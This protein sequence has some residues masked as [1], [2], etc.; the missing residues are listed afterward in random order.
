MARRRAA[1]RTYV[2]PDVVSIID[3]SGGLLDPRSLV[4]S[5]V[6]ALLK[7]LELYEVTFDN[8]FDR[9]CILASLAGFEVKAMEPAREGR[10]KHDAVIV[11][12]SG[13]SKRGVIFYNSNRPMSRIVF[14][15]A[16]EISHS[17]FPTSHTGARFRALSA[18]GSKDNLEL[19]TLCHFGASELTMPQDP[20][21]QVVDR[22]G[23]AISHVDKIR[24]EFGTSF[25]ACLYRLATTARFPAAAG[26]AKFRLRLS[27][28]DAVKRQQRS[29]FKQ[30]FD[31]LDMPQKKYRRQSF[32]PS[33]KFPA[34][35]TIHWNNSFPED[36][37][38]YMAPLTGAVERS[39]ETIPLGRGKT[40]SCLME[41]VVAPFQPDD[42]DADHPDV[43]FLLRLNS[44]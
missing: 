20:F 26:L 32:H 33:D 1:G 44:N 8:A 10:E 34:G 22:I 3:D 15:I 6:R 38:L 36:T 9:V 30:E 16:H 40:L 25:E 7:Q 19:E 17:F 21:L 12:T 29:L 42:V 14:S 24:E 4:I 27:E 28:Q 5:R 18:V 35:L 43:F 23:F 13:S 39:Y 41:S 11:H 31:E 37:C 2:D